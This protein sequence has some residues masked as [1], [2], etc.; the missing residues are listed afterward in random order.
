MDTDEFHRLRETFAQRVAASFDNPRLLGGLALLDALLGHTE[1]ALTA[2]ERSAQ[3]LPLTKDP[4]D[5]VNLQINLAAVSAWSGQLDRAFQLRDQVAEA[6]F[7]SNFDYG[8]FLVDPL[9]DP[10]PH[11]PRCTAILAKLK[12]KE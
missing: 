10:L 5:G 7:H 3:L 4:I 12:P 8:R 2:A 1:R 11:D 9:W 6:S